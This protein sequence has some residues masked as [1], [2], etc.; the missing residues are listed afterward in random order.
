M[1]VDAKIQKVEELIAYSK[2]L[3]SFIESMSENCA[4]F[5]N[6]MMQKLQVLRQKEKEA[7][8]IEMKA[9]TEWRS[10]YHQFVSCSSEEYEQK[11]ELALKLTRAERKKNAAQ[12]LCHIVKQ[13]V[14]V[15][16]GAVMCMHENTQM[17]QKNLKNNID[18]GRYILKNASLQ[19][20]QYKENSKKL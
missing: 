20:E 10:I 1:A 3:G 12:R 5:N 2:H 6:V 15:A 14:G 17:V 7:I 16:R 13:E 11:S 9:T 19:L 8:E 4:S 18:K